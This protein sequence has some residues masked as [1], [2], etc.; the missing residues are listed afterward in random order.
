[1]KFKK[2]PIIIEAIQWDGTLKKYELIKSIFTDL[3][4]MSITKYAPTNQAYDWRIMTL[5]GSYGVAEGDWIIRGI[6][7]EYYPCKP[8]IFESTYMKVEE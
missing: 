1:M 7:G 6:K 5:E 2:K 3:Q 4:D 8:D